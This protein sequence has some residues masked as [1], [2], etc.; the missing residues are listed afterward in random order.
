M[1]REQLAL[2]LLLP[3]SGYF[4]VERQLVITATILQHSRLR[5]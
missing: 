4:L 5:I 1:T 3:C 2:S